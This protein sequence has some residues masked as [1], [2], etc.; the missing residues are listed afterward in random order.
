MEKGIIAL[1]DNDNMVLLFRAIG[2]DASMENNSSIKSALSKAKSRYKII[3]L[4]STFFDICR[5]EIDSIKTPYPIITIIDTKRDDYSSLT[6]LEQ[7]AK[8][9]L[10][11]NFNL[12]EI[13]S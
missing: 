5:S 13:K 4:S 2:F 9:I 7:E 1:L 10:G 8:S 3:Y 11:E 12:K 6:L